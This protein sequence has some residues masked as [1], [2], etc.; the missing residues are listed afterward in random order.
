MKQADAD[1]VLEA[2]WLRMGQQMVEERLDKDRTDSLLHDRRDA[3]PAVPAAAA[4]PASPSSPALIQFLFGS[5]RVGNLLVLLGR[6]LGLLCRNYAWAAATF[7]Q[8]P[9]QRQATSGASRD[10]G[11]PPGD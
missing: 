5:G 8:A 1:P 3:V 7:P 10:P 4:V 9:V 2:E 11:A 6:V